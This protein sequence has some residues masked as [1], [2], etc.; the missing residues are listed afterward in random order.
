M[1]SALG[2][3]L[4][5]SPS[6]PALTCGHRMYHQCRADAIALGQATRAGERPVCHVQRHAYGMRSQGHVP[7]EWVAK[8]VVNFM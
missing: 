3:A 8:W 5:G 1:A 6:F 2:K 4:C 7:G